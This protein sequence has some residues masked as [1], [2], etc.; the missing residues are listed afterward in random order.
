MILG[1]GGNDDHGYMTGVPEGVTLDGFGG[2]P[3]RTSTAAASAADGHGRARRAPPSGSGCRSRGTRTSR[4]GTTRSTPSSSKGSQA[5]SERGV[6]RH[7]HALRRGGRGLRRVPGRR[8]GPPRARAW[9]RRRPLRA[10]RGRDHR[11]GGAPPP[12]RGI[13]PDELAQ[14]SSPGDALGHCRPP[15]A[16]AFRFSRREFARAIRDLRNQLLPDLPLA[17]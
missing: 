1:L 7:V 13:R 16:D 3:G 12:Q 2:P 17:V 15:K 5:T 4:G 11:A 14:A 8:E 10:C 6:R 9:A